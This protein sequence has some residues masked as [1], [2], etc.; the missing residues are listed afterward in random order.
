MATRSDSQFSEIPLQPKDAAFSLIEAFHADPFPQKVDL[1]PGFYRD[2]NAKPWILPSVALAKQRLQA[3]PSEAHHEHLPM[4]GHPKLLSG[5]RE[6]VFGRDVELQRIASIQTV[7]GTGA[8]H[9]AAQLL[10]EVIKPKNVWISAPSWINHTEIWENVNDSI[11]KRFYPYYRKEDQSLDFTGMVD[12]LSSQSRPGDVVVLHA[13]AHNPSGLDLSVEQWKTVASVC[14]EKKLFPLFDS[15]YQGF[16]TGDLEKD[17]WAIRYFYGL[18]HLEFAVAQSFSKNFGIYGERIGALHLVVN[19]AEAAQRTLGRLLRLQRA[20]ITSPPSYGAKIVATILS[21]EELFKQ[22][23]K[24]LD[25]MSGRIKQ[26][27]K[28]LYDELKKRDTPGSWDHLL[29][30]VTWFSSNLLLCHPSC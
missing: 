12:T 2:E 23:L 30:E 9:F 1:C 10:S 29:V 11:N 13:C 27:R 6:L 28:R 22:W 15:A 26:M 17:A 3:D 19:S 21:D 14:V 24:D 25:H 8:N 4:Q 7:S 16:A 5:A 18:S 20:Q